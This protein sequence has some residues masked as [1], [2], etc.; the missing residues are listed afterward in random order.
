MIL[1]PE[2]HIDIFRLG[3][4][5]AER[6][7][8]SN[9]LRYYCLLELDS[10]WQKFLSLADSGKAADL[11]FVDLLFDVSTRIQKD[12]RTAAG[13]QCMQAYHE[14]LMD[15]SDISGPMRRAANSETDLMIYL[16]EW[17]PDYQYSLSWL[18]RWG[19]NSYLWAFFTNINET[20]PA[21]VGLKGFMDFTL[22]TALTDTHHSFRIVTLRSLYER[23]IRSVSVNLGIPAI[24]IDNILGACEARPFEVWD[25][26]ASVISVFNSRIEIDRQDTGAALA[27]SPYFNS[28]GGRFFKKLSSQ[29]PQT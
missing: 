7:M 13:V 8:C 22:C 15:D 21:P 24:L 23:E 10:I 3:W 17:F 1:G 25:K 6:R 16:G 29:H 14:L 20:V 2:F 12:E 18:A 11:T 5:D 19:T 4:L 9:I 27:L 26:F 28:G